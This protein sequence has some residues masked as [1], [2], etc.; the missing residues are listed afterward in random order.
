VTWSSLGRRQQ[1]A[2]GVERD[3]VAGGEQGVNRLTVGHR[4]RS[5][6][7]RLG[8]TARLPGRVELA[9]PELL[10]RGQVQAKD[11]QA[12]LPVAGGR[13]EEDLASGDD[14]VGEPLTG[15]SG[16]PADPLRVGPL[17]RQ[18]LL[19]RDAGAV[20]PA[21]LRPVSRPRTAG[22]HKRHRQE[23][24]QV[25]ANVHASYPRSLWRSGYFFSAGFF[26]G[27]SSD[28]TSG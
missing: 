20:R 24:G 1:V 4:S 21:K 14:G 3:Q 9:L 23:A 5:G 7:V 10:A 15:Q 17:H 13:G 27:T 8:V 11:V 19:V 2:V 25:L 16:F 22:P 26:F 6:H 18:A 12:A 28:F